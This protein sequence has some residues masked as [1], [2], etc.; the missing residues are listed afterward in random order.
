MKWDEIGPYTMI[1]LTWCDRCEKAMTLHDVKYVSSGRIQVW[2]C[3]R[4]G[5]ENKLFIEGDEDE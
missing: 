4:C 3:E 5:A 2:R 1:R